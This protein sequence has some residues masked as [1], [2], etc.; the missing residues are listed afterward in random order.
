MIQ[1][2][3]RLKVA[4][5]SGARELMV[6]HVKGGSRHPYAYVGDIVVATVKSA[7]PGAAVKKG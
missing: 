5:N 7:I 6:F 3:T 1:S 4:D 2:Q